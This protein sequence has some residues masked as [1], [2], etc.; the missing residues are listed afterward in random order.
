MDKS[1]VKSA[2]LTAISSMLLVLFLANE[3]KKER[4]RRDK[5]KSETFTIFPNQQK[6]DTLELDL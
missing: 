1:T 6:I 3:S 2:I 4:N 5:S